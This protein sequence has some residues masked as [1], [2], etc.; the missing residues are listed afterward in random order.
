M[1]VGSS[2][3][4]R[5]DV[6]AAP[7]ANGAWLVIRYSRGVSGNFSHKVTHEGKTHTYA[8]NDDGPNADLCRVGIRDGKFVVLFPGPQGD[9]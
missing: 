5:T 4:F 3:S 9:P 7:E 8:W 1:V 6:L 2:D